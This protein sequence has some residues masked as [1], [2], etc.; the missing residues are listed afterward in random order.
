[1]DETALLEALA[2]ERRL[3]LAYAPRRARAD[4]LAVLAL[5]ARLG[6]VIVHAREPLIGQV[7][8][9][10]WRERFGEDPGRWPTGEPLL[11]A[12]RG[13]GAELPA[14]AA[15]VD[16]WEAL[17][18]DAPRPA[19]VFAELGDARA[20]VLGALA[21]RLGQGGAVGPLRAAARQ[22]SR[23][24]LLC[25][26]T[27]PAERSAVEQLA[28]PVESPRLPRAMRPLA[29]LV[30]L[31]GRTARRGEARPGDLLAA[32]RIGLFGR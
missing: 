26:L 25:R 31:A 27:D 3:A 10:W 7:R 13:W 9:A 19:Q 28:Q 20:E 2:P 16:A 17:L 24:D 12:L 15:L 5:D 29:V 18:A 11:A 14:L 6:A 1:M 8:L 22:W 32:L 30:T 21:G 23:A 4:W